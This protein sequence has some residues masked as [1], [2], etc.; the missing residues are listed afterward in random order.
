M[1]TTQQDAAPA[2]RGIVPD[3]SVVSLANTAGHLPREKALLFA[4]MARGI[5]HLRKEF[6]SGAEIFTAFSV[7]LLIG[8]GGGS[9]FM[10]ATYWVLR[11]C[12]AALGSWTQHLLLPIVLILIAF[13]LLLA[14][15]LQ[16]G[17]ADTV[18]LKVRDG[19][20]RFIYLNRFDDILGVG[21]GAAV[22]MIVGGGLALHLHLLY[23]HNDHLG[24]A[25]E[26]RWWQCLAITLDNLFHGLLLDVCELYELRITDRLHHTFTSASIFLAFRLAFDGFMLF[27]LFSLYR[28]Q[29]V[30]HVAREAKELPDVPTPDQ[31]RVYLRKVAYGRRGWSRMFF[32]EFVLFALMEKHLSDNEEE[33]RALARVFTD[34]ELPT[35]VRN[36]FV[37]SQ[38]KSLF[39]PA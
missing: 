31:L 20:T 10:V 8:F 2:A 18:Q 36:L 21:M 6:K 9:L 27:M 28:R 29:K 11:G 16:F 33:A 22:G 38:G 12:G 7:V 1:T 37:D 17:G 13:G 25:I 15:F 34:V 19:R 24:L 32:D 23:F 5:Q 39:D 4:L 3:E 26:G 30:L 35:P 14:K